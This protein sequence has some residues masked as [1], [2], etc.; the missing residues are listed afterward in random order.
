[1]IKLR[2]FHIRINQL[3][4]ST[5]GGSIGP[6]YVLQLLL[7]EKITKLIIAQRPLNPEKKVSK[8]LASQGF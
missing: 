8:N 5:A 4:L 6:L 2:I 3:P 7:G 1:M